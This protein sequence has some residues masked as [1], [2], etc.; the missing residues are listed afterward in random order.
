MRKPTSIEKIALDLISKYY[1]PRNFDDAV[2]KNIN[3]ADLIFSQFGKEWI[4]MIRGLI[5]FYKNFTNDGDILTPENVV[6]WLSLYNPSLATKIKETRENYKWFEKQV[7]N[8]K[9][10]F[11]I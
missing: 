8:V 1:N 5:S 3:L 9:R 10:L 7:N 4:G 2:K 11:G 6:Y